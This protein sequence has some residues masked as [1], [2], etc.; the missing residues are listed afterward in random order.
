M[1]ACVYIY[2]ACMRT[3]CVIPWS[4]V[5]AQSVVCG[6]KWRAKLTTHDTQTRISV[7]KLHISF[8]ILEDNFIKSGHTCTH[9]LAR[10]HTLHTRGH[11]SAPRCQKRHAQSISG[12]MAP[13]CLGINASL[14]HM[15]VLV[16]HVCRMLLLL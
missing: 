11:G 14:N 5:T 9:I 6:D 2:H 1:L 10:V 13:V 3:Q 15:R 7:A 4:I 12:C 16:L 8:L